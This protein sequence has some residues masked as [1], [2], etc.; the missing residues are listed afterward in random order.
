MVGRGLLVKTNQETTHLNR[1]NIEGTEE[2]VENRAVMGKKQQRAS[3][4]RKRHRGLSV[5]GQ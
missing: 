5:G 3:P 2:K 4:K 1:E